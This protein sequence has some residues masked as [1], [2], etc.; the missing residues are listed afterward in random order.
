[1]RQV[2][3]APEPSICMK[4][5]RGGAAREKR[6]SKNKRAS[7]SGSGFGSGTA[8]SSG[9]SVPRASEL[10]TATD[11]ATLLSDEQVEGTSG[12]AGDATPHRV[13]VPGPASSEMENPEDD[14]LDGPDRPLLELPTVTP[15]QAAELRFGRRLG[16]DELIE[17]FADAHSGDQFASVVVANRDLVTERLLYRFTSAILQVE[18]RTTDVET[19]AEEARNMR[20]LRKDLIA[21]CWSLDYPLKVELQEA[22]ARL[23]AV[24]QGAN[25]QKDVARNCGHSTLEVD[26]F[27]IV[28]FAA[29]AAWEERGQENPELANV[30]MQRAL[31]SAAEACRTV[32]AVTN[33]LS[34]SL[35]AV[36]KILGSPNPEVQKEIV[37]GLEDETVEELAS[38]TEQ[39]RLFPSAAYG[40]LCSR[41]TSIVDYI[42]ASKYDVPTEPVRPFRFELAPMDRSSKLVDF[43]TKSRDMNKNR[44]R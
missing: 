41:M 4:A 39:I 17:C 29:V 37:D 10:N 8:S 1:M 12:A 33:R 21:Y 11:D 32:D 34:S 19:R 24:L 26:A 44:I 3:C 28:I 36:Q 30:D 2:Q 9:A 43:S 38:F 35:K 15:E 14:V 7:T 40:A 6:A 27:W 25:V 42:L 31:A 22:E 20:E 13:K 16:P 23:L 18:T 5:K